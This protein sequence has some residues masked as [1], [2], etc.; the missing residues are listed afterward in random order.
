VARLRAGCV[1]LF[2][3][4][5]ASVADRAGAGDEVLARNSLSDAR[6]RLTVTR[7]QSMQDPLHG[8]HLIPNC[9]LTAT[10]L[11]PPPASFYAQGMTVMLNDE[12]KL[13]PYDQQAGHKTLNYFSRLAGLREAV[14]R[15]AGEALW[16]N[17]HNQLESASVANVFVVDKEG[18]LVT[19][20]TAEDLRDP[21]VAKI[22]P[23]PKSCVLPGVTRGAILDLARE[24]GLAFKV[25]PI[26]VNALLAADEVFICNSVMRIM[27]VT[28]VE[29]HAVG[30]Q[31]PGRVTTTLMEML[32]ETAGR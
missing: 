19:P 22:T 28:R 29:Q 23:Y 6:L 30:Q 24:N 3:P 14:R 2:V 1:A 8:T 20:P 32:A 9:F 15:G 10:E 7:G 13:N 4:L 17:V 16:F 26:D 31:G 12:Q 27:P 11:A 25:G 18:T 5:T 21:A